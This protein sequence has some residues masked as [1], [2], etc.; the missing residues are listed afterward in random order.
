MSSVSA[1]NGYLNF[2]YILI[3]LGL[4]LLLSGQPLW[5]GL[6]I[7]VSLIFTCTNNNSSELHVRLNNISP[8][9]I[10]AELQ[11]LLGNANDGIRIKHFVL[12]LSILGRKYNESNHKEKLSLSCQQLGFELIRRYPRSTS[13]L[14]SSISLLALVANDTR[15]RKR[16]KHDAE[17]YDLG[18]IITV[19][20]ITLE[21]AKEEKDETKE[22]VMAET[23]RK[24]CLFIGAVCNDGEDLGLSSIILSEGGL[25]LILEAADWYRFHE[26]VANWALWAIFTL[27]F[28]NL[29]AKA[30]LIRSQG[31]QVTLTLMENN[32]TCKEVI[33][34]GI[35]ILFDLLRENDDDDGG[36][37]WNPWEVRKIAV[38][39]GIQHRV[40]CAMTDFSDTKDIIMMGQEILI[41]TGYR[42]DIPKLNEL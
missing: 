27:S 19:L 35:A 37:A 9:E 28:N 41:G 15:V 33:R 18:L 1:A 42:G 11:E 16:Y 29:P 34:H 40:F 13:L 30:Q 12:G 20:K 21:R 38:V 14:A 8:E 23:L 2:R 39:S 6:S 25:E 17:H 22:E 26:D 3:F 32:P 4:P 7:L 10:L 31:I 5:G 24:G 36:I